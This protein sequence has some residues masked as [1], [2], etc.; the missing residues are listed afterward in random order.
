MPGWVMSC[1]GRLH[2][3]STFHQ[4]MALKCM[5]RYF[6][7]LRHES[8]GYQSVADFVVS[9]FGLWIQRHRHEKL[10]AMVDRLLWQIPKLTTGYQQ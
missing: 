5:E 2:T 9:P 10:H 6:S 1:D 4:A 7:A 8:K 3:P